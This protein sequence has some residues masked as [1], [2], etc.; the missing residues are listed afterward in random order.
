VL[1]RLSR[2]LRARHTL[3]VKRPVHERRGGDRLL[4]HALEQEGPLLDVHDR[5]ERDQADGGQGDDPCH[6]PRTQ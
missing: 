5:R 3:L 6:K 2:A 4:V 1:V